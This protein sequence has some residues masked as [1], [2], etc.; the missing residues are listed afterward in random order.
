MKVNFK[1]LSIS[2]ILPQLA[3]LVGSFWTAPAITIWYATL[4]KP[5]FSPPN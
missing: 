4:T 3:G 2:L 5:S 1:K